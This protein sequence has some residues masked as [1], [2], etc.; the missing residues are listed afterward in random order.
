[1]E[2]TALHSTLPK[3]RKTKRRPVNLYLDS[4]LVASAQQM[5]AESGSSVSLIVEDLLSRAIAKRKG[6]R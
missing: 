4:D 2:P 6:K 1:M 5:A 3:Q